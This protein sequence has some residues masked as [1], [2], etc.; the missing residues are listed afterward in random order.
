MYLTSINPLY[1]V[2]TPF[3]LGLELGLGLAL[4]VP[5]PLIPTFTPTLTRTHPSL[6]PK[7]TRQQTYRTV[8]TAHLTRHRNAPPKIQ[9]HPNQ[10][11]PRNKHT[12]PSRPIS[13]H[14]T[15][16]AEEPEYPQH[17]HQTLPSTLPIEP[18]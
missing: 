16:Q 2:A 12:S 6:R 1:P 10:R 7:P 14:S 18:I 13:S 11:Q 15:A 5:L 4:T 9:H 17:R 3:T 8:K